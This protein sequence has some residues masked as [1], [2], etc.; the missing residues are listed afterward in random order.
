MRVRKI[1][2]VVCSSGMVIA[3]T[4]LL[5]A[6]APKPAEAP[7]QMLLGTFVNLKSG[8]GPEYMAL[9]TNEVMPALKK[10]PTAARQAWSGG[11]FGEIGMLAYFSVVPSLAQFDGTPPLQQAL[12]ADG[13]AA[14]NAKVAKLV[15]STRRVLLRTR[16]DLSYEPNRGGSPSALALVT[17]VDVMPGRKSDFEAFL[18]RDVVPAM[19]QAKVKGYSVMEVVYGDSINS[20]ITAVAYDDYASIGKGHPFQV[21]LGEEGARKLDAKVAGMLVRVERFVARYRADLSITPA[22]SSND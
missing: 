9:Q 18:K 5:A 21:A 11:V 1:A 22:K 8:M 3:A 12:G 13:A 10:V 20:Y 4:V 14:L 6:Q 15:D 2:G 19:Q 16:P 7:S 17:E